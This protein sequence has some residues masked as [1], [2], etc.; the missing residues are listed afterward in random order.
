MIVCEQHCGRIIIKSDFINLFP[1]DHRVPL[2]DGMVGWAGRH[3]ERLL[4][5]NV[6]AE[7]RY[8]NFYPDVIPTCSELSV[9][10]RAGGQ[11]VGVLDIQSPQFNAF[12]E[13]D[14]QVMG[15]LTDQIAVAIAN[16]QSYDAARHKQENR[17]VSA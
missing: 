16:A 3:G 8:V 17:S 4:A 12:D 11:T 14:M 7:P 1:P 5:N 6:A 13:N 9:P 10:I 2:S 15:T